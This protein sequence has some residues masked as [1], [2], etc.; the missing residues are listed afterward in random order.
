VVQAGRDS[1]SFVLFSLPISVIRA[2][3]RLYSIV[4]LKQQKGEHKT[5]NQNHT[6]WSIN[7]KLIP[8]E[9]S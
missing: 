9:Q 6:Y 4:Y 3:N 7:R 5:M 8:N 1:L 2:L